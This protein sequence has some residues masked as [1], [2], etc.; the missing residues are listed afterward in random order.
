MQTQ[1]QA[2]Y[3]NLEYNPAPVPIQ[4]PPIQQAH[5]NLQDTR[6]QFALSQ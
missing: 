4:A 2:R 1:N 5:P 3:Y 6:S